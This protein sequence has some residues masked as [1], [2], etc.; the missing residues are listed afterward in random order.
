MQDTDIQSHGGMDQVPHGGMDQVPKDVE[1]RGC[2]RLSISELNLANS[3]A[4]AKTGIEFPGVLDNLS[5]GEQ[6]SR[7]DS[8]VNI[9]F[10]VF[11]FWLL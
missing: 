7:S 2:P 4:E 3:T 1:R 10:N 5:T 8:E 9:C 11:L 6:N